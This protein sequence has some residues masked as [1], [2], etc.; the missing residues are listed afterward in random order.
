[1]IVLKTWTSCRKREHHLSNGTKYCVYGYKG[2][3]L[4]G[5]IPLFVR[6]ELVKTF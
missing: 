2:W 5:I 6:R 3:F 1:M 4:L